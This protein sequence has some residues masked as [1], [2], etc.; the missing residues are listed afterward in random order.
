LA[1]KPELAK[2]EVKFEPS[3]GEVIYYKVKSGDTLGAIAKKYRVSVKNLQKWNKLS[4][5]TIR[6][7][8][9]LKI[10]K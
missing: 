10:Y 6:I 5:T 9:K 1:Y 2:R 3:E 4:S 7:G 8:Q